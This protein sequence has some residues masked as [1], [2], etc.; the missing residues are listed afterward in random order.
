MKQLANHVDPSLDS[1]YFTL[2]SL[3]ITLSSIN[4]Q[5][6][7]TNHTFSTKIHVTIARKWR[8]YKKPCVFTSDYVSVTADT[9][10]LNYHFFIISIIMCTL[11]KTI[12]FKRYSYP[13]QQSRGATVIDKITNYKQNCTSNRRAPPGAGRATHSDTTMGKG[14]RGHPRQR[15]GGRGGKSRQPI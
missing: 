11:N 9:I 2:P 10:I 15:D 13:C 14:P 4:L 7:Q 12:R 6:K 8:R 3:V 1:P 5:L